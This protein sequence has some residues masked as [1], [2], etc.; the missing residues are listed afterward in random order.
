MHQKTHRATA[1]TSS[2]RA[3]VEVSCVAG[4]AKPISCSSAYQTQMM[5][6]DV[7]CTEYSNR[8]PNCR[9]CTVHSTYRV[10]PAANECPRSCAGAGAGAGAGVAQSTSDG[11]LG[12]ACLPPTNFHLRC[13]SCSSASKTTTTS[14]ATNKNNKN[15]TKDVR[16]LTTALEPKKSSL[17]P[18][19]QLAPF[20]RKKPYQAVHLCTIV[21]S[22]FTTIRLPQLR[23][24]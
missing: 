13:R 4:V 21:S 6:H 3:W 24:T 10:M 20:S 2:A 9:Y 12:A 23:L 18:P 7:H 1:W 16:H 11:R 22:S 5:I 17:D 15:P 19:R 14:T 8:A